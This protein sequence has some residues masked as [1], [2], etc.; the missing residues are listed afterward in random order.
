MVS[1]TDELT[2][3]TVTFPVSYHVDVVVCFHVDAFELYYVSDW[4]VPVVKLPTPT[5][6]KCVLCETE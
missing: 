1:S 2:N 6:L 5:H 4:S 3:T